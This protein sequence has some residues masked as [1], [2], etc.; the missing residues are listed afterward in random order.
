MSRVPFTAID[1]RLWIAPPVL[2][3]KPR[4]KREPSHPG[5]TVT[6]AP[7]S[8][9]RLP[10]AAATFPSNDPPSRVTDPRLIIPPPEIPA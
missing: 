9:N 7:V 1:P 8:L 5:S 4:V 3:A 2:L 6:V 10:P